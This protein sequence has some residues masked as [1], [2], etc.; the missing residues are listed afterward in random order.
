MISFDDLDTAALALI[1]ADVALLKDTDLDRATPCAGWNVADL[2]QHMNQR[3]HAVSSQFLGSRPEPSP[4]PRRRFAVAAAE[5]TL[6]LASGGDPIRVPGL[7]EPVPR[8]KVRAVHFIDML[9]HRWDLAKA[10]SRPTRDSESLA[11][12]AMPIARLVTAPGSALV[13]TAYQPSVGYHAAAPA[14]D[15]LAALLGRDPGWSPNRPHA[16]EH[17]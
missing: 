15:R 14:I 9:T 7:A 8:D 16:R 12:S 13:G 11:D 10:L 5:W 6:A 4:D 2:L 17:P 3:H 1:A